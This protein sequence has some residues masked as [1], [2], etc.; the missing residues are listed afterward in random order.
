MIFKVNIFLYLIFLAA[1]FLL[2]VFNGKRLFLL[3]KKFP[4]WLFLVNGALLVYKIFFVPHLYSSRGDFGNWILGSV[5]TRDLLQNSG[6]ALR[7]VYYF[8]VKIFD[9]LFNAANFNATVNLDIF[10]T[11]I[12]IFAVFFIVKTLFK[13][14]KIAAAAT[15][16]YA[17]SPILLV[18]SLTEE[19]T[20]LAVFFSIQA[21]FF[22]LFYVS[23]RRQ[24]LFYLAALASFLAIGSRPE[25]I[26][27]SFIFLLF[28]YLFVKNHCSN[29]FKML[30]AYFVFVLPLFF[31]ATRHFIDTLKI[32]DAL[33]LTLPRPDHLF[34]DT[35]AGHWNFFVDNLS[36]NF[37]AL[38]NL[39]TL[40]GVF[41]LLAL[42]FVFFYGRKQYKK[43][44]LFFSFYFLFVLL[45]YTFLH[46]GGIY[47]SCLYISS[48]IFPLTVLAGGGLAQVKP[49]PVFIFLLAVFICFS[50]FSTY[51]TST[52][53]QKEY[54][55]HFSFI[56]T[57]KEY[58]LFKK[59]EKLDLQ[60]NHLFI[61][62]GS[63]SYLFSELPISERSLIF[64]VASEKEMKSAI[65]RAAP[66][67]AIYVYQGFWV[68][69][70][71]PG[72]EKT[73]DPVEFETM[74][75]NFLKK[76]TELFSFTRE[77]GAPGKVFFYQMT[78]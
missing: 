41:V 21:L 61:V 74:T 77:D 67:A 27:F 59:N 12:N 8:F 52:F 19:F 62:N 7:P 3:L 55:K 46:S 25:Y 24:S 13:N 39:K 63:R 58:S 73:I 26:I 29:Y 70:R 43:E 18:I 48:L 33:H 54:P 72:G 10:L 23:E 17:F 35:L 44:I 22:A 42:A 60:K 71:T 53:A 66:G 47:S 69:I 32:D 1:Y 78:K 64:S 2:L 76:T 51:P 30:A 37:Y 36:V 5:G 45:Y 6:I 75:N 49:R 40:M 57:F 50:L 65:D 31:S 34:T 20:N 28:S 15:L 9:I 56:S 4:I 14:E 68:G 16:L 11:F 38:V